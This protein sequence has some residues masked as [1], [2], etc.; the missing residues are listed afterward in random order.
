MVGD[1][2]IWRLA[3]QVIAALGDAA[4]LHAAMRADALLERGDL[5]GARTWRRCLTAIEALQAETPPAGASR[6]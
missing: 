6:H 3:H 1:R 2:D 4:A 5:A